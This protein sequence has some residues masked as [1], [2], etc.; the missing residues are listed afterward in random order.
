MGF[1]E[2]TLIDTALEVKFSTLS[3]TVTDAVPT[4]TPVT[5]TP[6]DF[7]EVSG[8]PADPPSG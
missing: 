3:V 8:A 6:S 7:E 1:P 2:L 4:A 5:E